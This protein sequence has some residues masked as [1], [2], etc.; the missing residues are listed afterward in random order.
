M[1]EQ[2]QPTINEIQHLHLELFR[3]VQY[4]LLNG[5]RI[6]QDLLAW[7]NLWYSVLPARFPYM[8]RT[9]DDKHYHPVTELSMLRHARWESWPADTLYIWT[10]V[11]ILPTLQQR[12]EEGWEA[13]E[14]VVI[15]P[16]SDE[17]MQF[18]NLHDEQ[19]RVLFVWWD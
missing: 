18:A 15:S 5:E 14:I 12:I 9:Q 13:S 16:E 17:E 2:Q 7:R 10:N 1:T 8:Y 6:V 3:H 19:D 11:E 4:N